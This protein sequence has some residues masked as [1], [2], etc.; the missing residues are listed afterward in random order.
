MHQS[1]VIP[2]REISCFY[3]RELESSYV[4]L[5]YTI[6]LSRVLSCSLF[7]GVKVEG[8]DPDAPLHSADGHYYMSD[9][10]RAL[11]MYERDKERN[12]NKRTDRQSCRH[13][14]KQTNKQCH[15]FLPQRLKRIIIWIRQFRGTRQPG[16][17]SSQSLYSIY[18][19]KTTVLNTLV[20]MT[21][22]LDVENSKN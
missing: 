19:K 2:L 3:Y 16:K 12:K 5:A 6:H 9:M 1:G 14:N 22:V 10:S 7:T 13:T 11:R 4:R 18:I 8:W 20:T 17:F 15:V 21:I